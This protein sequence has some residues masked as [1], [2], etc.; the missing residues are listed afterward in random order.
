M[1]NVRK[2]VT[3]L[4]LD[5]QLGDVQKSFGLTKG[6]VNRRLEFTLID[7]GRP[8]EL[9]RNWTVWLV[10]TKPDGTELKNA[11]VVERGRVIYD[12]ASG[13]QLSACEGYFPIWLTIWNEVGEE[14]YSPGVGVDVR[15]G[16]N[17]MNSEDQNTAIAELIAKINGTGEEVAEI[18]SRLP[19]LAREVRLSTLTISKSQWEDSDPKLAIATL[20]SVEFGESTVT[21]SYSALLLPVDN[22]TRIESRSIDLYVKNTNMSSIGTVNIVFER[23]G[24]I[25]TMDLKYVVI[26]FTEP[27]ETGEAFTVSAGFVGIG[28]GEG[29]GSGGITEQ[30]LS[31]AIYDHNVSDESHEDI[32]LF[33]SSLEKRLETLAD[34]DDTTLDQLSEIVAYIKA[35]KTMIDSVTTAKV[36]V[37]DI[38]DNLNTNVSNK[39]LSAAQGVKLNQ[40]VV[41]LTTDYDGLKKSVDDLLYVPI[42]ID[43]FK[44]SVTSAEKGSTVTDT[45]LSWVLNKDPEAVSIDGV[46]VEPLES[47]DYT[48]RDLAITENKKFTLSATDEREKTVTKDAAINFYDGVYCGASA[49]PE[50]YNSAFIIALG[51]SGKKVLRGSKLTSFT[52][53]AGEGEYIYYCLPV[54]MGT[55]SFKVGGFDGG[56]DLVATLAYTNEH[57]HTEQ[58]Y[59]YRS[60][61]AGLGETAVEVK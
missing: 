38:V 60:T 23:N 39:P 30:E 44:S 10:G 58:Y 56:F 25:P 61:N 7:G 19:E 37:V 50:A 34:S 1:Q 3:R 55:C 31:K 2:A 5:L 47:A 27:N 4:T 8:F 14:V 51:N 45:T 16:P 46:A 43:E 42:S 18:Q 48:M 57:G 33:L 54:S 20:P 59:I 49:I 24:D 12:L 9:P 26:A 29:G 53:T 22:A 52:V 6:D 35:N 21:T 15:P 32:R 13:N 11:C 40:S 41:K 17:T 28:A 36:N